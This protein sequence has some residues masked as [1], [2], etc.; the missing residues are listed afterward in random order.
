MRRRQ[1]R[2]GV[3]AALLALLALTACGRPGTVSLPSGPPASADAGQRL[4]SLTA[5]D[6]R[7]ARV[8]QRLS[9]ANAELCPTVRMSAGW[10]LH[11]ANQYSQDLRPLAEAR[12]GLE[13]DLPGIVAAPPDSAAASA[14]LRKG[15]LILAVNGV[16]L[17]RG[18]P[19]GAPAFEG[20]AVNMRQLDLALSRGEVTLTI[21][22]DGEVRPIEVEPR[23][24][25]GYDVQ[26]DPSDELNARAD[27]RRLFISTALAGFATTDDELAVI[28]GHELAHHVLRHRSWDE[29]GG[30]G[31][32]ANTVAGR[33]GE[34]AERQ[35]D[36]T[37]LF[38]AARAGYDTGIA[39]AFWRRFGASNRRVRYPQLR[40]D[41]AGARAV[42]LE[43]VHT[44]IDALRRAGEPVLP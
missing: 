1:A 19:R 32:T 21:R 11:S 7:V 6:E 35:A 3:F 27:G 18:P 30:S 40:H 4:A 5:L 31:R 9:D 25:C 16:S 38:L 33:S 36:R 41:S 43:A 44:E 15:D 12:F 26:L 20:L 22:R 24:S 2:S 8:A 28:L 37:G 29:T 39:A 17:D 13:G 14:G 10:A 34:H 42:A 23:R